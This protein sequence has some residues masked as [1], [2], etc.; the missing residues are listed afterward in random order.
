MEILTK[1]NLLNIYINWAQKFKD[2]R[3]DKD[4]RFGQWLH[5]HFGDQL[6]KQGIDVFY[7]ES[8]RFSYEIVKR[9]LI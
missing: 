5:I 9:E 4:L 8:A 2:G 1:A 3:N 7:N 6:E